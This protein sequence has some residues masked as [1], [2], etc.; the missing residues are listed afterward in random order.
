MIGIQINLNFVR[1]LTLYT[2]VRM[3]GCLKFETAKG[4]A[5]VVDHLACYSKSVGIL[6]GQGNG[7]F[8]NR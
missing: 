4:T 8:S 3:E 5:L 6:I 2:A 7:F 1:N